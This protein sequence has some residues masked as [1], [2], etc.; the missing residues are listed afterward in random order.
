MVFE[1]MSFQR[2]NTR[3]TRGMVQNHRISMYMYISLYYVMDT[4]NLIGNRTTSEIMRNL[5]DEV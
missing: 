2:K 4:E 1:S 5:Y 3:T